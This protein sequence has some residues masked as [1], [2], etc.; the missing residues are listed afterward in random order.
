MFIDGLTAIQ[1]SDSAVRQAAFYRERYEHARARLPSTP[2]T[3][4]IMRQVVDGAAKLSV[5][6]TSPLP[7][8]SALSKA[9][10]EFPEVRLSNVNW[11]VDAT[12]KRYTPT[13]LDRTL[14]RRGIQPTRSVNPTVHELA[15]VT[16]RIEPFDGNYRQALATVRRFADSLRGLPEVDDVTVESMPLDIGPDATLSGSAKDIAGRDTAVFELRIA[17]KPKEAPGDAG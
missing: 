13:D 15:T 14:S 1:D 5:F 10:A 6:E 4:Q 9:L 12:G 11:W 17:L 3:T 16:A 7:M 8:M 2:D